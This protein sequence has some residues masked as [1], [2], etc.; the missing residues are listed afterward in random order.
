MRA[1]VEGGWPENPFGVISGPPRDTKTR[2]GLDY[3]Y[4]VR[5][6]PPAMDSEGQ[7]PFRGAMIL[8]RHLSFAE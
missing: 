4:F 1:A 2:Q 8:S 6:D 3:S 7:G 5:F